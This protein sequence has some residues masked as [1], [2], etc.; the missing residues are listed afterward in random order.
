MI[1]YSVCPNCEI[2]QQITKLV[3]KSPKGNHES[4][5]WRS[6]RWLCRYQALLKQRQTNDTRIQHNGW[7]KCKGHIPLLLKTSRLTVQ[8]FHLTVSIWLAYIYATALYKICRTWEKCMA[9]GH[10][11]FISGTKPLENPDRITMWVTRATRAGTFN[12]DSWAAEDEERTKQRGTRERREA[13]VYSHKSGKTMNTCWGHFYTV[14]KEWKFGCS[15][16]RGPFLCPTSCFGCRSC[17]QYPRNP[18]YV[19]IYK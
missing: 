5:Y 2:S 12:H 11:E 8:G 18:S 17:K 1:I 19:Q 4:T 13:S 10:S 16:G 14:T 7:S 9:R 6:D 3:M 15:S